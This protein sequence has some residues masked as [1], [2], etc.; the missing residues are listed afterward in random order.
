MY[1]KRRNPAFDLGNGTYVIKTAV[2]QSVG[3]KELDWAPEGLCVLAALP[4]LSFLHSPGTQFTGVTKRDAVGLALST[5]VFTPSIPTVSSSCL[6]V[7]L[8]P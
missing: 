5:D 8:R 1:K 6:G 2:T 3:G 7:A 4:P